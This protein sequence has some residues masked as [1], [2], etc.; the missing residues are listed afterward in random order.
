M[1]PGDAIKVQLV[2]S[3]NTELPV[4][5]VRLRARLFMNGG[6]RYEFNAG[7]TDP[8]G[9]LVISYE[10]L[11]IV[12]RENGRSSLMDYNNRLEECDPELVIDAY[13]PEDFDDQLTGV[14]RY[15]PE[16]LS[17]VEEGIG[18]TNTST[19]RCNSVRA[20]PS[21][22]CLVVRLICAVV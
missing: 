12:R 21:P 5:S 11:E 17:K 13:T 4:G 10:S 8:A 2:D 14:R 7:E 15:Y 22:D 1:R 9:S 19:I 6:K 20:V 18:G 16:N 3:S